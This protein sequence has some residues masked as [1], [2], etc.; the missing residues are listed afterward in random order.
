MSTMQETLE[1]T[2]L[3]KIDYPEPLV[4]ADSMAYVRFARRDPD[5]WPIRS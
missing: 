4:R 2:N 3:V 5:T 1:M